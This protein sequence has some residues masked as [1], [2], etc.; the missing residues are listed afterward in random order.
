[1]KAPRRRPPERRGD[2]Q[3]AGPARALQLE[4]AR[5]LTGAGGARQQ[6][7][8]QGQDADDRS[9]HEPVDAGE[10]LRRYYGDSN[11]KETTRQY[12]IAYYVFEEFKAF[13]R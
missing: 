11:R 7:I 5:R 3:W 6:A 4:A 1:M 8:D 9:G 12:W 2:V 13:L 10:D